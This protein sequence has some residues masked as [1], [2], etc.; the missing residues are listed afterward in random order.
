MRKVVLNRF[1]KRSVLVGVSLVC[2]ILLS[3]CGDAMPKEE[4]PVNANPYARSSVVYYEAMGANLAPVSVEEPWGPDMAQS[5]ANRLI[6]HEQTQFELEE[7]GLTAL[8]PSGTEI[9]VTV[10]DG[11]AVANI[12][13]GWLEGITAKRSQN[14]VTAM[15]NTLCD[16]PNVDSV[17]LSLNGKS[18]KLGTIDISKPFEQQVINPQYEANGMTPFSVYYKTCDSGL[19]VPVT[20]YLKVLTPEQVVQALIREPMDSD[21][22]MSLFPEGTGLISAA[23]DQSGVLTV[24]FTKELLEVADDPEMENK[25][26]TGIALTCKQLEGVSSV[27]VCVDGQEYRGSLE[28]VIATFGNRI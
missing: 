27:K 3:S 17:Q 28:P 13:S 7:V 12:E 24:N 25:L 22:L 5:L 6:A 16:L 9:D 21:S 23:I 19:L 11:L 8:L 26:L 20:K 14:I 10:E 1:G 4:I 2:A 15:V 18:D